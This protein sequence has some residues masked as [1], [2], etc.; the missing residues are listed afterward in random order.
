MANAKEAPPEDKGGSP[1][2]PKGW[3]KT[4]EA[5]VDFRPLA[6][7][8]AILARAFQRRRYLSTFRTAREALPEAHASFGRYL[9]ATWTY[10]L[11]AAERILA[12]SASGT[13]GARHARELYDRAA[14]LYAEGAH[15]PET[16]LLEELG[17]ALEDLYRD[18]VRRHHREV[19]VM[20]RTLGE[21][22]AMGAV[23][24]P[25]RALLVRAVAALAED[26][27]PAYLDLAPQVEA[28]LAEAREARVEALRAEAGELLPHL[29]M[30]VE[31][32]LEGGDPVAAHLLLAWARDR[33][34]ALGDQKVALVERIIAQI[35][36][37]V[38]AARRKGLPVESAEEDL[39]GAVRL[40]TEGEY[41]QA[42]MRARRAYGAVREAVP[43]EREP[44]KRT[45]EG[46]AKEPVE[47]AEE[48]PEEETPL[49]WC[50]NCG[51]LHVALEK[52][53]AVRCQD[54]G[55][56]VLPSARH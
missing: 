21:L 51:S 25:A 53:E 41:A 29:R 19:Q 43:T 28:T 6:E 34:A 7:R 9:D 44:S 39:E 48:E 17:A 52:D 8:H 56:E 5:R 45:R 2:P 15:R 18:E 20:G 26:D 4:L 30:G 14:A 35:W 42:L 10:G 12:T 40:V 11:V 3:A 16:A 38:E 36:P 37:L 47:A 54:C 24:E 22:E 31:A 46:K 33:P 49:L 23:A 1:S 27:R 50:F 13:K 32:A 55:A